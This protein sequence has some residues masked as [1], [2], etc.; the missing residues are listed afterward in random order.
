MKNSV[1]EEIR[2]VS[3]LQM[4]MIS[5][6]ILMAF[7]LLMLSNK[8]EI[9]WTMALNTIEFGSIVLVLTLSIMVNL[10][11]KK[12]RREIA[13]MENE[14]KIGSY[15]Q[16]IIVMFAMLEG[17]ALVSAVVFYIY[18]NGYM[19]LVAVMFIVLMMNYKTTEDRFVVDTEYRE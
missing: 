1:S 19:L 2:Q 3:I 17:G 8:S 9:K 4:A 12:R 13:L 6:V 5:G 7:I 10:F 11:Y 18:G 14:Q 16:L 15:R